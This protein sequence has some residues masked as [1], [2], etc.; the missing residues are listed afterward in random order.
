MRPLRIISNIWRFIKKRIEGAYWFTQCVRNRIKYKKYYIPY[1]EKEK[2]T[3]IVIL[4]NGPSLREDY[5][6]AIKRIQDIKAS[7]AVVN[8]FSL[9]PYFKEIKPKYY[10]IAD[11]VFFWE[12]TSEKNSAIYKVIN[13]EVNWPMEFIVPIQERFFVEERITNPYVK[14]VPLCVQLY[15]VYFAIPL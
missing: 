13:E 4:A 8:H 15:F 3:P 11:R 7:V 2:D 5:H 9:T 10:L 12:K 14:V 1:S 6:E